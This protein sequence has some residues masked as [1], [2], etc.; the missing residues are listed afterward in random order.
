MITILHWTVGCTAQR[1]DFCAVLRTVRHCTLVFTG[2]FEL[3]TGLAWDQSVLRLSRRGTAPHCTALVISRDQS[4][5]REDA[6]CSTLCSF[7]QWGQWLLSRV[8]G[9]SS[10]GHRAW[11]LLAG[12]GV[13]LE[14]HVQ[15]VQEPVQCRASY[16]HHW[17]EVGLIHTFFS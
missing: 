8:G 9:L 2:I 10:G 6:C 14:E 3:A 5:I 11:R 16:N 1:V 7:G 12:L 15:E 13:N 4:D 17:E